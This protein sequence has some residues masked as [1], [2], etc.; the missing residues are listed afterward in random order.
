MLNKITAEYVKLRITGPGMDMI[1]IGKVF[2]DVILTSFGMFLV[3]TMK[4][5]GDHRWSAKIMTEKEL[6]DLELTNPEVVHKL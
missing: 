1:M 2:D 6:S 4:W 5:I 3:G